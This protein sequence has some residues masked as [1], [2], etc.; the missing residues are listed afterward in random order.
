MQYIGRCSD[1]SG[2]VLVFA[3]QRKTLGFVFISMC[4]E[5]T[6]ERARFD[7]RRREASQDNYRRFDRVRLDLMHKGPVS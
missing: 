5:I 3:P 1:L 2:R 4:I 7:S 6:A